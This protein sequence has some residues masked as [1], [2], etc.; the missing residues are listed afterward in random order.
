MRRRLVLA[1][2]LAAAIAAMSSATAQ[3]RTLSMGTCGRDVHRLQQRLVD[4]SYLP[5]GYTPGCYDYRTSQAVMALQGW[6]RLPRTGVADPVTK[7][8][9][10]ESKTP[11]AWS[12]IRQFHLI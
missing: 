3:A 8:K 5:A 4:R 6:V 2:L 1:T 11:K 7:V 12:G 10:R 9:L